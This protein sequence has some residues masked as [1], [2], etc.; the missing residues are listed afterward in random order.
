MTDTLRA[1]QHNMYGVWECVCVCLCTYIHYI[2]V[3]AVV[4]CSVLNLTCEE[5]EHMKTYVVVTCFYVCV[6]LG[7]KVVVSW[8]QNPAGMLQTAD[9]LKQLED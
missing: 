2:L 4:R 7:V 8:S 5:H 6:H 1:T 9:S 3:C